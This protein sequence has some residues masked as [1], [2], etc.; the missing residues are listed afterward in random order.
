MRS[1]VEMNGSFGSIMEQVSLIF[2]RIIW[3]WKTEAAKWMYEKVRK[4]YVYPNY[5]QLIGPQSLRMNKK[6]AIS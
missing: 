1:P 4:V 2:C 5:V 3:V 6:G